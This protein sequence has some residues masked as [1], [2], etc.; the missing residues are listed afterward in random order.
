MPDIGMATIIGWFITVVVFYILGEYTSVLAYALGGAKFAG[1]PIL[2]LKGR[3]AR[4]ITLLLGGFFGGVYAGGFIWALAASL[5][6]ASGAAGGA[7]L[8][9]L[10]PREVIIVFLVM[11]VAGLAL[12][13]G[14]AADEAAEV[15][16][17]D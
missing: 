16:D 8:F 9:G 10:G 3:P 12:Y 17:A 13:S 7:L 15:A 5:I 11:L 14:A 1:R 4:K 2:W 6:G